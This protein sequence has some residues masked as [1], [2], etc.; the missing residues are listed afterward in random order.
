MDTCFQI[1][2]SDMIKVENEI[3]VKYSSPV[4]GLLFMYLVAAADNDGELKTSL[5]ELVGQ[6][7]IS[8]NVIMQKLMELSEKNRIVIK[9][10]DKGLVIVICNFD[11]YKDNKSLYEQ[12]SNELTG[13]FD[14]KYSFEN[15]WNLYDKKKGNKSYVVSKWNKLSIKDKERAFNFIPAYVALTEEPFRK[16]F[17]TFL[18]QRTWEDEKIYTHGI[19]VPVGSFNAKLVQDQNL[20]VQFVQRF[21]MKV[22]GTG[23]PSVTGDGLTEKRRVLFNIAYCLHFH[24][25]KDVMEKVIK[26]PRLNG[27]MGFV[28]DFDY[29]FEPNNFLRIYEGR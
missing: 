20:F 11:S 18:N 16:Q 22:R 13:M 24:Q 9:Q 8:V 27:T 10:T 1:C 14:V 2:L 7:Q 6:T 5:G 19:A 4:C 28:A 15:V 29:I 12:S 25:I 26:N 17:S 3:L 23:I 21:N